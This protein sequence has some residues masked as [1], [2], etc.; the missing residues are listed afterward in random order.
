MKIDDNIAKIC[1]Y[2][3]VS[4]SDQVDSGASLEVQETKILEKVSELKGQLVEIY[5]DDGKTGTNMNRPGLNAMLAR[6]SKGDI[7]YLIIYDSSRLSRET[8]DYLTIRALLSKYD[9]EIVALTGISS[10]GDD[11]YS[12]FF[13]EVLA[14]VNALHPRIS[15]YKAKQTCTEKFKAGFYPSWAPIGYKQ[16]ENPNP[17]GSYD[18]RITIVNKEIAPFITQAF[19]LYASGDHSIYTI[20]QYLHI[21]GVKGKL[22]K[23]LHYSAVYQ[24]LTC[25]FYYG[26]MKWAGMEKMGKHTPLIDKGTFDI[27]QVIL[28]RKG[29]FGIRKR[30]Y[31]FLLSGLAFCQ[32]C[33]R[34]YVAEYHYNKKYVA[35][36]GK[37]GMYHCGGLGKKGTGCKA[38]YVK[39]EVLEEQVDQELA[40]LEFKDEFIEA[41]KRNITTVYQDSVDR[42][43]QAKKAVYNRR[44]ALDAKR[45][46]VNDA[47]MNGDITAEDRKSM[48]SSLEREALGIQKQ[49][50]DVEKVQTIDIDV[51]S[52]ILDL[53]KDIARVYREAD[54]S[55]KRA[56]LHFFF[57]RLLIKDKKI[58]KIEYQP[59]IEVL[60]QAN[61]VI[62][63]TSWLHRVDSDHEPSPYRN[64]S[65]TK[66]LDYLIPTSPLDKLG[67]TRDRV[68]SLYTFHIQLA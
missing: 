61:T 19:K 14:A 17:K 32:D 45:Q 11:P 56:Y 46:R 62:L 54:I 6:C 59:V 57:K 65:V 29:D 16:I 42:I 24:I 7:R 27:V 21:N 31:T 30:K 33:G 48:N 8:K 55:S 23:N 40:K 9:V 51:I 22:G 37:L 5:H 67:A 1:A 25:S 47:F 13:D 68:Y 2:K 44:D 52:E 15:G 18:K 36:N 28:R 35:G 64:P 39:L 12:K 10:F 50:F 20:R 60:K 3:R 66:G 26:L 49:L 43:K 4:T 53:T 38:P 41:V 58:A 63:S 34:R